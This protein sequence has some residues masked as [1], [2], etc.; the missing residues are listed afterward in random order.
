MVDLRYVVVGD[1]NGCMA[2]LRPNLEC[3][4]VVDGRGFWNG[5]SQTQL[6]ILG[7]LICD[8]IPSG[9]D[10]LA[11]I[12]KYREQIAEIGGPD[13][14]VLAG[15]HDEWGLSYLLGKSVMDRPHSLMELP[16]SQ[17]IMNEGQGIGLL[18]FGQFGANPLPR[19]VEEVA[20]GRCP[21]PQSMT[22]ACST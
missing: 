14:I 19:L 12:Q 20:S 15:N 2:A 4:G 21:L 3:A 17:A 8:R 7:D 5:G 10:T 13:P 16:L 9:I 6:V 22:K 11:L 1:L 18:E